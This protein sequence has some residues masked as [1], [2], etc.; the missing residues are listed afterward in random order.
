M[1]VWGVYMY[2]NEFTH[3]CV[4]MGVEPRD[5]AR[6]LFLRYHPSFFFNTRDNLPLVGVPQPGCA[7]SQ[8]IS[9]IPSDW[10]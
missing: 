6:V 8:E 4:N 5:Q 9:F 1:C 2:S 7:E 10:D 3:I